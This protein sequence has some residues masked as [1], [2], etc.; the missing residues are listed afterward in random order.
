MRGTRC[1][2]RRLRTQEG[3]DSEPSSARQRHEHR[4]AAT[5]R[6]RPRAAR[7]RPVELAA[8]LGETQLAAVILSPFGIKDKAERKLA[9]RGI[10]CW[11]CRGKGQIGRRIRR[12]SSR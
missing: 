1:E 6:S 4:A 8:E 12:R 11:C 2:G 10:D 7:D 9:M 5:R 3:E